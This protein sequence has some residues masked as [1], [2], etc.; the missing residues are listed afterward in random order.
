MKPNAQQSS[1]TWKSLFSTL[2]K[3]RLPWVWI[4]V[5]MALNLTLNTMLL[6][7]PDMTAGL[8]SGDL[9]SG[10]VTQ[11]MVYYITLGLLSFIM[12]SGQVQAQSLSV[13]KSRERIWQK[14]LGIKMSYFDQNDPSDLMSAII[15][16]TGSAVNSLVNVI[17]YLIPDLYYVIAALI[18]IHQYHWI[19][20]LSC[21]AMIPIKYLYSLFVGKKCRRRPPCSMATLVN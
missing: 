6:N 17:I 7:L 12:V 18:R 4:L 2:K 21:F 9:S 14:M 11:A 10:A 15:N 19:L 13:R 5:A 1:T 8:L 3:L 16:D 20:A